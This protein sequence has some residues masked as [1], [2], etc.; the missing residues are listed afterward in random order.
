MSVLSTNRAIVEVLLDH[1]HLRA[2]TLEVDHAAAQNPAVQRKLDR[3]AAGCGGDVIEHVLLESR[4]FH[5]QAASSLIP[6]E[7]HESL[8]PLDVT[9]ALGD[10]VGRGLGLLR[11]S[12]CRPERRHE[13]NRDERVRRV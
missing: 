13:K 1:Q 8:L 11:S 2:R 3:S 12:H 7:R 4:Y 9:G 10:R 5:Q 6:I